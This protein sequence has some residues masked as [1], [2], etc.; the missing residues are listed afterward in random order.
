MDEEEKKFEVRDKRVFNQEGEQVREPSKEPPAPD[1]TPAGGEGMYTEEHGHTHPHEHPEGELPPVDFISFV[2]SLGASALMYLG[3]KVAPDQPEG[4]KDLHG[5]KQMIDLIALLEEK[6]K[7]NLT[8]DESA[9]LKSLLYNL[10]MR[11]V[12]EAEKK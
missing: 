1:F 6:T 3:E 7:G 2:G 5:A 10:R 9:M 8:D 12:H 11:Y 4:L